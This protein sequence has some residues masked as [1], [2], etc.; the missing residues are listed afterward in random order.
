MMHKTTVK[1]IPYII[2]YSLGMIFLLLA[3]VFYRQPLLSVLFILLVAMIPLSIFTFKNSIRSLSFDITSDMAQYFLPCSISIGL[4]VRNPLIFPLLN[5]QLNYWF[6]NMYYPCERINELTFSMEGRCDKTIR[7]PVDITK[8]GMFVLKCDGIYLTDMLHFCTVRIVFDR[9]LKLPVFPEKVQ[10]TVPKL[11]K[12]LQDEEEIIWT[13]EGTATS[14]IKQFREYRAGDRIKD[15]HWKLTAFKDDIIVKEYEKGKEF[16]HLIYPVPD[17][18]YLQDTLE[19]FYAL[20][21]YILSSGQ[22]S[23]CIIYDPDRGE[24][25]VLKLMDENDLEEIMLRLFEIPVY[26]TSVMTGKDNVISSADERGIIR[27]HGKEIGVASS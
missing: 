13:D 2:A 27:I 23:K 10:I 15:I 3:A 22:I 11:S 26:E 4:R 25:L 14:D 18:E 21:E 7:I 5:C 8:A 17:R 19:T 24:K 16:N 20:C 12:T 9:K 6:E 1:N